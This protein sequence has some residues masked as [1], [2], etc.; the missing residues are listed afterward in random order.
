MAERRPTDPAGRGR[1]GPVAGIV[2]ALAGRGPAGPAGGD[3]VD[4]AGPAGGDLA[5]LAGGDPVSLAVRPGES[6]LQPGTGLLPLPVELE[7]RSGPGAPASYPADVAIDPA[8]GPEAYQLT[9]DADRPRIVAG[10]AAGAFSARL[11]LSQLPVGPDGRLPALR[12]ADRP[13]FGWRGVLLD[14]ARHFLGVDDVLAFLDDLADLKLNRL[15][16]HLTDDQ[17][18]RLQI[19]SWPRLAEVGGR[20]GSQGSAGGWYSKDDFRRIVAHAA[21]RHIVV[22]PEVD[23]PGHTNA[24][25]VAYP[26]L[27]CPGVVPEPY[28]GD[29]VGFSTLDTANELVY[30]FTAE[31][32]REVAELSPGPW[33]HLG[34]D[35]CLSTPDEGYAEYV[36]RAARLV[37]GLGRIPVGWHEIGQAGGLPDGVVGQYWNYTIPEDGHAA[38]VR[39]LV[40]QG[41]KV[42]LSPSDVAYFDMKYTADDLLGQDW[43][44]GPTSLR[45]AYGWEPTTVIDG[46]AETDLLGVEAAVFTEY[47]CGLD[48][49]RSLAFP[50]LAA[51]A[52]LAWSPAPAPGQQRDFAGFTRR[53][54]GYARRWDAR[55]VSYRRVPE[56]DW[57]A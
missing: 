35:E 39:S 25:L 37:T 51:F 32:L 27:A 57:E 13:R 8:L 48:A 42:I 16:L 19:D 50:R 11:T 7:S 20:S 30:R 17:G 41:G 29:E 5:D 23:L 55:G 2:A 49:V 18:W 38:R 1:P 56:V 15:H 22:V 44:E 26:E 46:L 43:A 54:A 45:E 31:V 52:E 3:P 4:L 40:A 12:V 36:R 24:A 28:E 33:L 6:P 21:D 10:D 34:G 9:T 14:V 53:L 47:L